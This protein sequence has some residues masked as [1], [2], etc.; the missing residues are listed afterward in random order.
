VQATRAGGL[1]MLRLGR[2]SGWGKGRALGGPFPISISFSFLYFYHLNLA[3]SAKTS[4]RMHNQLFHQS[5]HIFQHDTST[6]IF[7]GFY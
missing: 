5:K 4:K 2:V 7:I 1:G 6:T 3:S